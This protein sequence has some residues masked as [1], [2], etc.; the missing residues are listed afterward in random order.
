MFTTN[1]ELN[2]ADLLTKMTKVKLFETAYG[3]KYYKVTPETLKTIV[4][5]LSHNVSGTIEEGK[6]DQEVLAVKKISASW[7]RLPETFRAP[8]VPH[9]STFHHKKTAINAYE[10]A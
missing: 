2:C 6:Q 10:R 1:R 8:H 7:E 3:Q 9:T 4:D 5:V